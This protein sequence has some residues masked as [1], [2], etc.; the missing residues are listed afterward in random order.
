[1]VSNQKFPAICGVWLGVSGSAAGT[2]KLPG[3]GTD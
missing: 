3:W 1:M 2:K